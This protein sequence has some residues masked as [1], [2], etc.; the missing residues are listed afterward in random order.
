MDVRVRLNYGIDL[1]G[2]RRGQYNFDLKGSGHWAEKLL[3]ENTGHE[4][5]FGEQ[6]NGINLT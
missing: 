5:T 6:E 2:I 3:L 1:V 4:I